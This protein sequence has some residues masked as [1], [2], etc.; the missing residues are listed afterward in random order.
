[1]LRSSHGLILAVLGLLIVATVM[2]NSASLSLSGAH[3][4]T[5]DGIF[6]GKHTWFAVGAFLALIVG[7]LVPVDRLG[8]TGARWW[9]ARS[10]N[11]ARSEW[12]PAVDQYWSHRPAAE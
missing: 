2:V 1:M 12:R 3:P 11:R 8:A 4:T 5:T 7:S 10:G 9:T 6:L